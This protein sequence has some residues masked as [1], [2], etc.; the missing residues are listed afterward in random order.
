MQVKIMKRRTRTPVVRQILPWSILGMDNSA[1]SDLH[2]EDSWSSGTF[3]GP[4]RRSTGKPQWISLDPCLRIQGG[5]MLPY[6]TSCF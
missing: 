3:A 4:K 2:T 6:F 1:L 5:D